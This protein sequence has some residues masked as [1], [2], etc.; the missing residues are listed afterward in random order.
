MFDKIITIGVQYGL[1]TVLLFLSWYVHL[2]EKQAWDIERKD[3]FKTCSDCERARIE[4]AKTAFVTLRD[5]QAKVQDAVAGLSGVAVVHEI[6]RELI[7][8]V[9]KAAAVVETLD[10]FE[11]REQLRETGQVRP[12]PRN[13]Q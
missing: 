12:I 7:E 5:V 11:A 9:G 8:T 3:L 6:Q 4:D 2:K 13:R 1:P 10:K